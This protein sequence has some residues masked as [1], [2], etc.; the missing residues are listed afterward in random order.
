MFSNQFDSSWKLINCLDIALIRMVDYCDSCL[1][2]LLYLCDLNKTFVFDLV[3][4]IV[5]I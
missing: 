5:L 1:S 2:L 3:I 4:I